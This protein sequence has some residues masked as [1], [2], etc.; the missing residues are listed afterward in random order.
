M[1]CRASSKAAF[2][3]CS[4]S[5]ES[6]LSL[7][8][9][10]PCARAGVAPHMDLESVSLL[11]MSTS[12]SLSF[13]FM[14]LYSLYSSAIGVRSSFWT[15]LMQIK[16][17]RVWGSFPVFARYYSSGKLS[18]CVETLQFIN[19]YNQC[20][21]VA[22]GLKTG[23]GF[24]QIMKMFHPEGIMQLSFYIINLA[25]CM[26]RRLRNADILSKYEFT[27]SSH[28]PKSFIHN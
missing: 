13:A 10:A 12:R 25:S 27:L 15:F 2:Q 9:P 6:K 26:T 20:C 17:K 14:C 4:F 8:L 1:L 19:L 7:Q 11:L 23:A 24:R 18:L 22:L 21:Q 5:G 28:T 16:E 3:S